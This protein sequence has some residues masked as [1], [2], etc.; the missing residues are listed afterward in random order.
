MGKLVKQKNNVTYTR[1]QVLLLAGERMHNEDKL[2]PSL[3]SDTNDVYQYFADNSAEI[4]NAVT[5]MRGGGETK[6]NEIKEFVAEPGNNKLLYFT[7]YGLAGRI[8]LGFNP[9]V[10]FSWGD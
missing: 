4:F 3:M 9:R 8:F 7:G 2:A 6:L 1:L 5:S 10:E